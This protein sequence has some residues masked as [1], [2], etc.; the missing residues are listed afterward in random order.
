[1][2]RTV[3]IDKRTGPRALILDRRAVMGTEIC[4]SLGRLGCAVD[5]V[6]QAGSPAFYSRSCA[7]RFPAPPLE[8]G[9]PF[10]RVVREVVG[11]RRYDAIFLCN[12][13]VLGLVMT[14]P[15]YDQWPG[16]VL[17]TRSSLLT[18]LSKVAMMEVARKAGV[19]IPKSF[20]PHDETELPTIAKDLG[21]PLIIKG[22]R[23]ESGNH[24]R[25][26]ERPG[27]L[28]SAYREVAA[29]E[30]ASGNRPFVQEYVKG[31]AYSVGGVFYQGRPLRVCA[32]R[33]LVGVPPLEGLTVR[34]VTERCPGLL[35]QA[36]KI[37]AA[38]EYSGLGHVEFVRDEAGSLH[39]LEINPRVWGTVG[40]GEYAGVDFFTPYFQLAHG[41]IPEPDLD[42][43]EGVRFHRIGREGKMIRRRPSRIFGFVRDCIDPSVRSDF[44]WSDPTPHIASLMA[45]WSTPTFR[46][47][48]K[49]VA[50]HER[51]SKKLD[52]RL[53]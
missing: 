14:L 27:K 52:Q 31:A 2:R 48:S 37:F 30:A 35:G 10:L 38:L 19:A 20:F 18:A 41:Q 3:P 8:S 15:E 32:H 40:I 7:N 43:R 17:S 34:G 49:E 5:V 16:L 4:R 33:K 51:R 26:V 23:G 45:R 25:L 24:V 1:M 29:L 21:F 47:G 22:D 12:E 9:A 28:R 44:R 42:F 36:F 13:E 6:A 53:T 50:G 11:A 39:F 46:T